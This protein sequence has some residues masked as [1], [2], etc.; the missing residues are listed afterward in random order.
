[1]MMIETCWISLLGR[2]KSLGRP[3]T[4]GDIL[5]NESDLYIEFDNFN[6]SQ[7]CVGLIISTWILLFQFQ[8]T[9]FIDHGSFGQL[10]FRS[11]DFSITT[12]PSA[13]AKVGGV[14]WGIAKHQ[15]PPVEGHQNAKVDHMH[16]TP[17]DAW[18]VELLQV[19]QWALY[20]LDH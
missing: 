9:E 8:I 16:H 12:I 11:V 4:L 3:K 20:G 13:L 2:S 17:F 18:E 19:Q 15:G 5:I 7:P 14:W 10:P 6:N 1:M